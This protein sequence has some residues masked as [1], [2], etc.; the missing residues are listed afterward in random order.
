M[1]NKRTMENATILLVD[2]DPLYIELTT[3]M[4][5]EEGYRVLAA[6]D[7]RIGCE[8]FQKEKPSIVLMDWNLP[9]VSGINLLKSFKEDAANTTPPYII[10]VTAKREIEFRIEGMEA[11]ADDYI[12]KPFDKEELLARLH[13]G[14]RTLQLRREVEEQARHKTVI[15]M[16]VS[17]SHEIAN[18]LATAML[19]HHR[20]TKNAK[21]VPGIKADLELL[22][23]QL[24]R[25]EALVRKAQSIENVVSVPYA[26]NITMIDWHQDDTKK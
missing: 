2:D 9:E 24:Q 10:M 14:L 25:M 13:V 26:E 16:A 18:P 6:A 11:G 20:I 21:D 8:V 1:E 22:G 15:E 17:V 12:T 4:L 7:G 23:Q 19:L 3:M 5:K